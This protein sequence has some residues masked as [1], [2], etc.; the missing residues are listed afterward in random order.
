[1]IYQKVFKNVLLIL[2]MYLKFKKAGVIHKIIQQRL[3][4]YLKLGV[5]ALEIAEFIE[6][7]IDIFFLVDYYLNLIFLNV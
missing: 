4:E 6:N 5:S 3:R 1:M 2:N 7:Q